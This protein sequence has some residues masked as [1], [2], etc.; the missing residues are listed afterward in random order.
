MSFFSFCLSM[1]AAA[2][3]L[4]SVMSDSLQPHGPQTARLL[5]PWNSP[6]RILECVA[7]LSFRE[8]SWPRDR[9]CISTSPALAGRQPML[10]YHYHQR[11]LGNPSMCLQGFTYN[12]SLKQ[13]GEGQEVSQTV[14]FAVATETG[15]ACV[16][17]STRKE[18]RWPRH[19][20][21][22]HL[23]TRDRLQGRSRLMTGI[24]QGINST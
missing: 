17:R 20:T 15:Q 2:A 19:M 1:S 24:R 22:E 8:S 12:S 11:Y 3:A 23:G 10:L 13:D 16:D 5:C 14:V 9:T 6:A 4:A 21:I 7:I 18:E